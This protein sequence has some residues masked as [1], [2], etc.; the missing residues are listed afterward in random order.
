MR[1]APIHAPVACSALPLALLLACAPKY[2][3]PSGG[4]EGDDTGDEYQI[5][6]ENADW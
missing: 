5:G 3:A 6:V 2:P 1:L 4:G